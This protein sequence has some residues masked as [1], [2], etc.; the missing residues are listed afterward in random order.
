MDRPPTASEARAQLLLAETLSS[1]GR[2]KEARDV[3]ERAVPRIRAGL[4]SRVEEV[5]RARALLDDLHRSPGSASA[6]E[7]D[8]IRRYRVFIASPGD[9]ERER[10][11]AREV[12][13]EL[14]NRVGSAG[15][16]VLE[17]V[18]WETH[19]AL[20][21]GRPQALINPLVREADLFIGIL[22]ARFGT[23]TGEAESGTVEEFQLARELAANTGRPEVH[24]FFSDAP[25]PRQVLRSEE[26][27]KQFEKAERFRAEYE[28][29]GGLAASYADTHEFESKLRS[30]LERW[31]AE[32]FASRAPAARSATTDRS[33]AER[34]Y[35]D[36]VANHHR[37]LSAIGFETRLRVP[38][39][40]EDIYVPTRARIEAAREREEGSR[41]SDFRATWQLA[42]E[43]NLRTLVVLGQPGSGKTTL[44]QHLALVA[45]TGRTAELGLDPQTLP[46]FVPLRQLSLETGN[47]FGAALIRASDP[48]L[49]D[50]P[51]DFLDGPLGEGRCLILLDGLDEVADAGERRA[52]S[53]WI[54]SLV[55]ARGGN[56]VVVT[57]RFAGY[58]RRVSTQRASSDRR[59]ALRGR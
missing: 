47:D 37:Y 54:E 29:V 15:G 44:L 45:A 53:R 21:A 24:L 8:S 51:R 39:P 9:V 16:F 38:I 35:R 25:V 41:R 6:K 28:S 33:V 11:I 2:P 10:Q 48:S 30:Q 42:L 3:L 59:R 43:R 27:K 49:P 12:V 55:A 7:A 50:L 52:V 32:R 26:G 17:P 23:D 58:A 14:S 46:V 1:L 57:A 13:L 34:A 31:C 19:A 5:K 4:G 56:R 40:L 36:R 18:G 20:G 22:W